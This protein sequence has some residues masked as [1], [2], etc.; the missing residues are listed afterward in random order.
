MVFE[1]FMIM[2]PPPV[3]D[4]GSEDPVLPPAAAPAWLRAQTF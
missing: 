2:P 4:C 3:P 1:V